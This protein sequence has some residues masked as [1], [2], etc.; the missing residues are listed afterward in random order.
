MNVFDAATIAYAL[1]RDPDVTSRLGLDRAHAS[2]LG[3]ALVTD[4]DVA[5]RLARNLLD[6]HADTIADFERHERN[7][8]A[9]PEYEN[10]ELVISFE[11][12]EPTR[13]CLE[14][15]AALRLVC[16]VSRRANRAA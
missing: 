15:V 6:E 10:G 3:L 8:T 9:K 12:T 2:E 1:L 5:F 13:R 14:L 7:A 16:G 4:A 11:I